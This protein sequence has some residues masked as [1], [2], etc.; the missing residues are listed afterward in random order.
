[1]ARS[2]GRNTIA[3]PTMAIEAMND[4]YVKVIQVKECWLACGFM[5]VSLFLEKS[6][7]SGGRWGAACCPFAQA[8]ED[9]GGGQAGAFAKARRFEAGRHPICPSG[10]IERFQRCVD[11]GVLGLAL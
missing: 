4:A 8:V 2:A 3:I 6:A 7:P 10:G 1:M 11:C 5:A 9:V